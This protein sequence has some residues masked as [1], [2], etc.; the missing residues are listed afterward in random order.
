MVTLDRIRLTGL[1]RRKPRRRGFFYGA[2]LWCFLTFSFL[3][4]RGAKEGDSGRE[5]GGSGPNGDTRR[6]N[7]QTCAPRR[8]GR[9]T[10][11]GFDGVCDPRR[12]RPAAAGTR[13]HEPEHE[14]VRLRP[15][16]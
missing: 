10:R 15:G 4:P 16:L 9:C 13:E 14:L 8:R 11:F 2:T 7:A 5:H 3:A 12:A 1:L 6:V